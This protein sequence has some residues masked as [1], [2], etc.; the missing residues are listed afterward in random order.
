MERKRRT[1]SLP[2]KLSVTLARR[3]FADLLALVE[4]RGARIRL[5]RRGVPVAAIVPIED[6]KLLKQFGK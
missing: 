6:L 5:Y 3:H 1:G 2:E 4:R